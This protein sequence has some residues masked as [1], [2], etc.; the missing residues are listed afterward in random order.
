MKVIKVCITSI[1]NTTKT[2]KHPKKKKER[3]KENFLYKG[4]R[5]GSHTLR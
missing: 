5:S 4:K 1:R 2:N 3:K